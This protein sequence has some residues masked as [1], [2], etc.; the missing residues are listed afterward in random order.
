MMMSPFEENSTLSL[1]VD[2]PALA[3]ALVQIP[4]KAVS[5]FSALVLSLLHAKQNTTINTRSDK[6]CFMMV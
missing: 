2:V 1:P 4:V 3:A 5:M 6:C